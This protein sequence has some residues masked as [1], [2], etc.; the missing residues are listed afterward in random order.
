MIGTQRFLVRPALI[1]A[2]AVALAGCNDHRYYYSYPVYDVPNSVVVAD[3]N[4]DGVA[5]IGFAATR[6]DGYYPNFGFAGVILQNESSTA[7]VGT[8]TFQS[9]LDYA[10]G[11]NPS[12]LA[13]GDLDGA[14]GP[15]LA[16]AN[17][18]SGSVSLLLQ[19]TT[20]T[21]HMQSAVTLTSGGV[22]YDVAIGDL[23]H[24]GKPDIAVADTS[25]S[26]NVVV[27]LQDSATAGSFPTSLSLATGYPATSVTIGD[28]DG[29]GYNDL[30]VA[31]E[32]SDGSGFVSIF[33]QDSANPGTFLARIDIAAGSQPLSVK[34]GNLNDAVDNLPD[35]VVANAGASSTGAGSS[36]V[37]VLLQDTSASNGFSPGVTYATAPGSVN[38]A[39]G[40]LNGDGH[41]D[42]V[43]ANVGGTIYGTVSVLLQ[44]SSGNGAFLTATNYPGI[45]EP[46]GVAI[47]NLNGDALPDIAVAD[48]HRATVMFNSTTTPGT[49]A[50]PVLVGN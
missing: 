3:F 50:A 17:A 33:Y 46:L 10:V 41:A 28:L 22:P 12:T 42:L 2:A 47:G 39:I 34:I 26:G 16:V 4:G 32:A 15:D 40:D 31:T 23:N 19:D 24:D 20:A 30:V 5:D 14:N 37:T 1:A 49:F 21:G 35:L 13:T 44:N 27:F 29:D 7:G 8:S 18:E 36:G 9:S 11:F 6:V 43:T 25:G 45:C 38:V 48:G